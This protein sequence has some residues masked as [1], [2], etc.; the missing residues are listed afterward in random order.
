MLKEAFAV[1]GVALLICPGQAAAGDLDIL[2]RAFGPEAGDAVHRMADAD[3]ADLRGGAGVLF[4]G[5]FESIVEGSVTEPL[6][7][8]YEITEIGSNT[9]SITAG[10]GSFQDFS[11]VLQ[12]ANVVG[13]FNTVQNV[14]NLNVTI[15]NTGD[16]TVTL[17]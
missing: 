7:D 13:N 4:T 12:V 1:C 9:V 8:G 10:F 15:N 5:T 17:R 11:G 14:L 3:L 2:G 16:G 6:P